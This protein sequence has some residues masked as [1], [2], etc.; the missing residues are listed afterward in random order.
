MPF[1]AAEPQPLQNTRTRRARHF[2]RTGRL[3]STA[4]L[5][6]LSWVGLGLFLW[7]GVELLRS[8]GDASQQ[9]WMALGGLALFIGG[10]MLAYLTGSRLFCSLCH[11]PVLHEKKCRK[12][13]DAVR[14]GPLSYRTSTVI[15]LLCTGVF[16][17]MY[18]G[19]AFRM[20]K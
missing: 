9:G 7:G 3:L 11:G 12:H 6:L 18:C 1:Q 15:S 14:L 8:H 5:L 17:C 4:F 2:P 10:R 20:R 13:A 16:R 19:T